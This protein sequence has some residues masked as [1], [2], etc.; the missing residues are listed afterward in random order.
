MTTADSP[1]SDRRPF[2]TVDRW[3]VLLAM[4][5]Y[6]AGVSVFTIRRMSSEMPAYPGKYL[7]DDQFDLMM[8][9]MTFFTIVS[10]AVGFAIITALL[11][12][13]TSRPLRILFSLNVALGA[14]ATFELFRLP[15]LMMVFQVLSWAAH[16]A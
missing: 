2:T 1:G 5:V 9:S 15:L 4:L 12:I 7:S 13:F 16:K 10:Y 14:L 3:L 11:D 8:V 6:A